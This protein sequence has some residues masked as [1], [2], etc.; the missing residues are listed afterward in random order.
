MTS[1]Q[2]SSTFSFKVRWFWLNCWYA[3]NSFGDWTRSGAAEL[4]RS[5][6]FQTRRLTTSPR[7]LFS[8]RNQSLRAYPTPK[9]LMMTNKMMRLRSQHLCVILKYSRTPDGGCPMCNKSVQDDENVDR[10]YC[11]AYVHKDCGVVR[12]RDWKDRYICKK[13]CYNNDVEREN[14]DWGE[15]VVRFVLF[16]Y[17]FRLFDGGFCW[18]W[19]FF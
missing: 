16:W 4:W 12:K 18:F 14:S 7:K 2:F 19:L 6:Q 8:V 1:R 5:S 17:I 15:S 10:C 9:K 3:D 11:M 13:D